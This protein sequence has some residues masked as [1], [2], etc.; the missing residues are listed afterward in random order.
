MPTSNFGQGTGLQSNLAFADRL[1]ANDNNRK[2][3]MAAAEKKAKDL[4][5]QK[6]SDYINKFLNTA[7]SGLHPMYQGEAKRLTAGLLM[8]MAANPDYARSA[9]GIQEFQNVTGKIDEYHQATANIGKTAALV[10]D[11][12][13]DMT[14]DPAINDAVAKGD[15]E[16]FKK[17][18]GGNDF[19]NL[20]FGTQGVTNMIEANKIAQDKVFEGQTPA[21]TVTQHGDY[22]VAN[23]VYTPDLQKHKAQALLY[24]QSHPFA[25]KEWEKKG[26]FDAFYN[27]LDVPTTLVKPRAA[28][29][30]QKGGGGNGD[31]LH[32]TGNML[33]Q[34][35]YTPDGKVTI[36]TTGA[37]IPAEQNRISIRSYKVGVRDKNGAAVPAERYEV[38]QPHFNFDPA[39]P[40]LI[41]V[42]GD[43]YK[44]PLDAKGEEGDPVKVVGKPKTD[45][46]IDISTQAGKDIITE[47]SKQANFVLKTDN[48]YLEADPNAVELKQISGNAK[49]WQS[50]A[51]TP[52]KTA[53]ATKKAKIKP[54]GDL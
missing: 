3:A 21:T 34:Q 51:S 29:Q 22:L 53:P 49:D 30:V 20:G 26:G 33:I 37:G 31:Y 54:I 35:N 1:W 24:Y 46:T 23:D 25:A 16:S 36:S 15:I 2:G 6:Q 44:Y 12:P 43:V 50:K 47:Y 19:Y 52:A 8:K 32:K 38:R 14:I 7:N 28:G 18:N 5:N 9:E 40:N 4:V 10:A 42:E 11:H 39:H 45:L 13:N 48:G 17:L 27:A 41:T